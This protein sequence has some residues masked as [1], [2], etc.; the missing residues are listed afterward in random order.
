MMAALLVLLALPLRALDLGGHANPKTAEAESAADERRATLEEMWQRRLLPPDQSA[1]APEDMRLLKKI[2]ASEADALGLLRRRFGSEHPW[3]AQARVNGPRAALTKDGYEKYMAILSQE[4][5][6]YF[7][8]KGADAKSVFRLRDWNDRPLFD[9][10]GRITD[11]GNIVYRRA[12]LNLEV[13]W[14]DPHGEAYGT[15]RPPTWTPS[16]DRPAEPP[17]EIP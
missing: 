15:R 10:A 4:A 14:K 3:A 7:E 8:S 12:R 16:A 1:W 17:A 2:R 11:E 9:G 13:F 6:V 5:I